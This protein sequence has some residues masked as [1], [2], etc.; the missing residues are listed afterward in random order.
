MTKSDET[1]KTARDGKSPVKTVGVP[2]GKRAVAQRRI[3]LNG[4]DYTRGQAIADF[5]K[6]K[7]GS[8]LVELKY[9]AFE[10]APPEPKADDKKTDK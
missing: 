10:D 2:K 6:I 9:V 5:D 7:N 4:K 3:K 8:R 1:T